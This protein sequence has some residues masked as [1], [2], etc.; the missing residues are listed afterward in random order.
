MMM[1]I[2]SC[3]DLKQ[4]VL[5]KTFKL[6]FNKEY[7][8]F[9]HCWMMR[10]VQSPIIQATGIV[11][12][13][14][15]RSIQDFCARDCCC[16]IASDPP[17]TMNQIHIYLCAN[18]DLLTK[19]FIFFPMNVDRQ[20]WYG[21]AAVNPWVQIARVLYERAKAKGDHEAYRELSKYS[22]YANG[23]IACDGL[24]EQE[25]TNAMCVIWFLNMASAY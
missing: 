10:N 9:F 15:T 7:I 6:W 23:L 11:S 16:G 13:F 8:D 22:Q 5:A 25:Y 21:W 19:K 2:Q 17:M 14:V 4:N 12:S 3:I 18:L 24:K 1:C 20:H